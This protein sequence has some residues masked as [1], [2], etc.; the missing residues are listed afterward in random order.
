MIKTMMKFFTMMF[1]LLCSN[2]SMAEFLSEI[3]YAELQDINVS[4]GTVTFNNKEY[5]YKLNNTHT[6]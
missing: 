5:K 4:D 1:F 6:Q 3:K 2:M